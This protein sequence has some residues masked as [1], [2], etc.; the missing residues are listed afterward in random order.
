M[1]IFHLSSFSV[2]KEG[3]SF[4]PVVADVMHLPPAIWIHCA[5]ES[6]PGKPTCRGGQGKWSPE[7][8]AESCW[9]PPRRHSISNC[10]QS[11]LHHQ[12]QAKDERTWHQSVFPATFVGKVVC[13]HEHCCYIYSPQRATYLS[14]DR[15]AHITKGIWLCSL[16]GDV[17]TF[18]CRLKEMTES[19]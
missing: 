16:S 7:H 8:Q 1:L 19:L 3:E 15:A 17:S 2:N 18:T 10:W 13:A 4:T 5:A 6:E 11:P 14:C 12:N 9:R